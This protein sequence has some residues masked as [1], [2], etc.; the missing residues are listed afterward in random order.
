MAVIQI[1]GFGY[2][3]ETDFGENQV[4]G[5]GYVSETVDAP[6]ATFNPAWAKGSN[7]LIVPIRGVIG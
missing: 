1:P 2:V 6:P 7:I 3:E 5:Y 4:A